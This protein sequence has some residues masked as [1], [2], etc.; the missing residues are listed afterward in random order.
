MKKTLNLTK[1]EAIKYYNSSN[2]TG[3]K[4]L[5]EQTFGV[6]FAKP[7]V[8]YE[9]VND[10]KSLIK[11]LGCSPLVFENPKDKFQRYLNACA[12][13]AK[14]AE[15]Y[16]E[17]TELN[18]RNTNIAKYMPYKYFRADGS[19]GVSGSCG[20]CGSMY[21]SARFYYKNAKLSEQSYNNFKEYWEDFWSE[22]DSK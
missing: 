16:N 10:L 12:I 18:W 19:C 17:G 1:E 2:D 4:S 14:V 13:L 5:L 11:H 9:K 3:F 8:I 7:L 21:A 6:E 22:G 20:W 15:V